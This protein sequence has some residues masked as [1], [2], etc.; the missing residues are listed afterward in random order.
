MTPKY[1]PRTTTAYRV[2][3]KTIS[4]FGTKSDENF[5]GGKGGGRGE[6]RGEEEE[7]GGI[8][9]S[10]FWHNS[11]PVGH[12]LLIHEVSRSQKTTRHS[13]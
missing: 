10:F 9:L 5:C 1:K 2:E 8:F 7:M 12:D 4:V 3:A 6:G 13:R 11:P